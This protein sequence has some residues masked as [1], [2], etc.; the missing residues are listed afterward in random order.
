MIQ[1]IRVQ[2]FSLLYIKGAGR[3]AEEDHLVRNVFLTYSKNLQQIFLVVQDSR[4]S[5]FILES[6]KNLSSFLV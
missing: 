3:A 5:D 1:H 2:I 6:M 4:N